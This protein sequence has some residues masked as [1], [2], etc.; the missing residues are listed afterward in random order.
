MQSLR[1]ATML[2]RLLT[3]PLEGLLAG[4]ATAI[5]TRQT[6]L[7]TFVNALSPRLNQDD[8]VEVC[9]CGFNCPP[10]SVV[11]VLSLESAVANV[12]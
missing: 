5:P 12:S 3:E 6:V 7:S 11:N 8:V 1:L 4:G 10:A 9:I 2:V